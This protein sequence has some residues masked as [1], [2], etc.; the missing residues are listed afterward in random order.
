M[1][2]IVISIAANGK[3][4]GMHRD[5]FSV[6]FLGRQKIERASEIKFDDDAQSWTVWYPVEGDTPA[7][8]TDPS[9]SGFDSYSGARSFEVEHLNR[10]LLADVPPLSTAGISLARE[11]RAS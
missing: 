2:D 8:A 10:C 11:L 7:W 9:L 6:G 1:S 5:E 3:V 4:E